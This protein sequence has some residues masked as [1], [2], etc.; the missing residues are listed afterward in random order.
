MPVE[1]LDS[2]L[3]QRLPLAEQK[4]NFTGDLQELIFDNLTC[5]CPEDVS[6]DRSRLAVSDL[7]LKAPVFPIVPREISNRVLRCKKDVP[8][9]IVQGR[10]ALASLPGRATAG[11]LPL[12]AWI[13]TGQSLGAILRRARRGGLPDKLRS[14]AIQV[15]FL[16]D[17][18]SL[19][20]A[21]NGA[22]LRG[23]ESSAEVGLQISVCERLHIAA[24]VT[25]HTCRGFVM[26]GECRGHG[27]F[28][29]LVDGGC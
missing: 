24:E 23:A 28:I 6:V 19:L 13:E 26:R 22:A 12:D 27:G 3:A 29:D 5:C 7:S 18:S 4:R 15:E 21:V 16:N 20:R 8:S 10:S 14:G 17:A 1:T 11:R 25:V 2:L 9:L